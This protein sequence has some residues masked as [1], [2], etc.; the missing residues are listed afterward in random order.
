MP[1]LPTIPTARGAGR[2]SRSCCWYQ[3]AILIF[4]TVGRM[5]TGQMVCVAAAGRAAALVAAMWA[6]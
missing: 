4:R 6:A 3:T 5:W 1:T 2:V